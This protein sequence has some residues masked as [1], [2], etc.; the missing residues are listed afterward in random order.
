LA[1]GPTQLQWVPGAFSPG[2]KLQEREA[3]HSPPSSAEVKKGGAILPLPN[4]FS[5]HSAL[6]IKHRENFTFAGVVAVL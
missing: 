3:D 5:W 6:L 4:M 1:L 2:V